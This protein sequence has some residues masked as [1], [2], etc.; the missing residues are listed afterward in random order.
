MNR[1][2]IDPGVFKENAPVNAPVKLTTSEEEILGLIKN[3]I[4]IT[5]DTIAESLGKNRTTIMRNIK[6]LKDGDILTRIGSDKTGHWVV[7]RK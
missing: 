1:L 3:D 5:Y 7:T 6:K 4:N 2:H